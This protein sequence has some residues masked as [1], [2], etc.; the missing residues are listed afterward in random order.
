MRMWN[1]KLG[2]EKFWIENYDFERY[3]ETL[4]NDF[5]FSFLGWL[6]FW[7]GLSVG[8]EIFAPHFFVSSLFAFLLHLLLFLHW[9]YSPSSSPWFFLHFPISS[10]RKHFSKLLNSPSS[11]SINIS[12]DLCV[13]SIFIPHPFLVKPIFQNPFS[14]NH[15]GFF[16]Q[17]IVLSN[18]SW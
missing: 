6:S 1:W 10:H 3:L 13:L 9:Q 17:G 8:A 4:K 18:F 16:L 12:L 11:I 15:N 7:L 2:N 5:F 14:L